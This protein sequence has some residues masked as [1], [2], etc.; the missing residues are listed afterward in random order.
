MK[1]ILILFILTML[2]PLTIY[3]EEF[4]KYEVKIIEE[5]GAI[6]YNS[7]NDP[8][9][10]PYEEILVVSN[11]TVENEK[12]YFIVEDI[13]GYQFKIESKYVKRLDEIELEATE[14]S[15]SNEISIDLAGRQEQEPGGTKIS[16]EDVIETSQ[17]NSVEIVLIIIGGGVTLSFVVIAIKN[18]ILL[19]KSETPTTTS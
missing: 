12:E 18:R 11:K 15:S 2:L 10:L 1:K 9:I 4:E 17:L 8:Q 16:S 14:M 13:N 19:K 7:N 3:A 5:K 6:A